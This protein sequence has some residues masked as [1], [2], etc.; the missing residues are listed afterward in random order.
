MDELEATTV[1]QSDFDEYRRLLAREPNSLRFAE[2]AECLRQS[3]MLDQ[4]KS[5]CE[6]GLSHHPAYATGYVV[7]GSILRDA[8]RHQEAE[9]A[10]GQALRL[11]PGHPQAHFRLGELFLERGEYDKGIAA[12]EAALLYNPDFPEARSKLVETRGSD[13]EIRVRTSSSD[14]THRKPGER[15]IWLTAD[16]YG[17]FIHSVLESPDI[18]AAELIDDDGACLAGA[19]FD[20]VPSGA[21]KAAVQLV[22]DTRSMLFRLGAGRL[23]SIFVRTPTIA[24]RCIPLGDLILLVSVTNQSSIVETDRCIEQLVNRQKIDRTGDESCSDA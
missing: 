2:Y 9:A 10:W 1:R 4:A 5:L 18:E 6:E 13:S 12:L 15:P 23:R 20:A 14:E 7:M 11:D 21:R 8:G 19:L 16:Q 3:G 24:A 22:A 17:S